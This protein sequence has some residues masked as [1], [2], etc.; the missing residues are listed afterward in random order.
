MTMERDEQF[1]AYI[2]Q[3]KA[4]ISDAM[5]FETEYDEKAEYQSSAYQRGRRHALESVVNWLEY[6]FNNQ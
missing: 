3:L 6:H 1:F 5:Q 4:D 2:R